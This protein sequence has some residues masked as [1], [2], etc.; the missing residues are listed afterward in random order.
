M[1]E[2]ALTLARFRGQN[3]SQSPLDLPDDICRSA[4]NIEW[5]QSSLGAK[6]E[7]VTAVTHGTVFT[8][9]ISALKKHVPGNA[10]TAAELWGVDAA[11]TPNLGRMA[12]ATTFSAV[13][14]KDAIATRPQD[15]RAV[16]FNGKMFHA[17]DS[18]VN[19]LHCWDG[20]NHRRV[21]LTVP[22]TPTI[23]N[24]GAGSYAA[25]LR[26]YR[27]RGVIMSG[28]TVVTRSEPSTS[29]SFTPSGTGTAA[30]STFVEGSVESEYTHWEIEASTDNVTFWRLSRI[31][32]AT[33]TYDDSALVATYPDNT[34]SA[35]AGAYENPVSF[36][37]IAAFANM[38]VGMGGWESG[39]FNSRVYYT[40]PLGTTGEG[41]DERIISTLDQENFEGL[42]ENDGGVAT[43][44]GGPLLG[45][46]LAFKEAQIWKLINTPNPSKPLTPF[47]AH[48]GHGALRQEAIVNGF[49]E[50]GNEAVYF[51][52]RKMGPCRIGS[53]GFEWIGEDVED[54][55]ATFNP[56]AT[57]VTCWGLRY[58][59]KSQIR[60]WMATG[61]ANDPNQVLIFH[62]RLGTW[63]ADEQGRKRFS[64]GWSVWDTPATGLPRA[65]CGVVF[66]RTPGTSMSLDER[67]YYGDSG[68]NDI[69]W[70][71][72][73]AA[74]DDA[75]VTY[76]GLITTK[77]YVLAAGRMIDTL[78][79]VLIAE[80]QS[81]VTIT[82]TNVEE[83]GLASR[84]GVA[85][86]TAA[87]SESRVIRHVQGLK[88]SMIHA[89]R[90]TI[91][92]AAAAANTWNLD[93]LIV[94]LSGAEPGFRG[95]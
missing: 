3:G 63:T 66:A 59:E 78:D 10:Q 33:T 37:Y 45:N 36:R 48:D 89:L 28:S 73:N 8:S 53:R 94:P 91:G 61:S 46:L 4:Q 71:G 90:F 47:L 92:D 86:L 42:N 72:D 57:T 2:S 40:P 77:D 56:A 6:R 5:F 55:W 41:D 52:D 38:L 82:V 15:F 1:P 7:G 29:A 83:F 49:D 69:F 85:V 68:A 26:Y 74:T 21:G 31:A 19:R 60:F 35:R 13:T 51:L 20:T 87:G 23:A 17:Y 39:A 70:R 81:S 80:A 14:P 64:G 25:T 88:S 79:P 76:A 18:T 58:A 30:R 44:F 34:A 93:R 75:G 16:S 95:N 54:E 12:A 9:R 11:A 67:P 62:E 43:G 32:K 65:R 27:T 50:E 22:G 84:T 24:T